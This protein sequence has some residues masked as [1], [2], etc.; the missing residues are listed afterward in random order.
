MKIRLK[1]ETYVINALEYNINQK[2]IWLL[3]NQLDDTW[4]DIHLLYPPIDICKELE[5]NEI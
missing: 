5:A 1:L 3:E 4:Y 2:S